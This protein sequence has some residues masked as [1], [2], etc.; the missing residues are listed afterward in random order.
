MPV[1]I[2]PDDLPAVPGGTVNPASALIIDDGAGVWKATPQ[3][4]ADGTTIPASLAARPTS[5]T[6]AASG[7]ADLLGFIQ[8][9]TGAVARTGQS[10]L[11]DVIN[12][13]D[14][15]PDNLRAAIL[16]L[17]S[18]TN[19]TTYVQ[20]A[21]DAVLAAGGGVVQHPVGLFNV[22]GLI[23][24]K[25]VCLAGAGFP[26]T[27]GGGTSAINKTIYK[28]VN[29]G[30]IVEAP[31][32]VA[33]LCGVVGIDFK[34]LGAGTAAKGVRIGATNYWCFI[35]N[36]LFDNFS[37]QAFVA[38]GLAAVIE[39]ILVTN[40]NL[41]IPAAKTGAGEIG[42]TD[43]YANRI[44][45][46]NGRGTVSHATNLYCVG[47]AVTGDNNFISQCVGEFS[48]VGVYVSGNRNRF[49]DVRADLNWGHGWQITGAGNQFSACFSL[50][51]GQATTNTYDNVNISGGN[52]QFDT[53][54][55]DF[56]TATLPRYSLNDSYNS[57]AVKNLY[58]SACRWGAAYGTATFNM[59]NFAGG[60]VQI[61]Q[62]PVKSWGANDA[63]PSVLGY[64]YWITANTVDTTITNFTNPA[65]GQVLWLYINDAKTIVTSG[66]TIFTAERRTKRL[67]TG[68]WYC[69]IF[70]NG[71]WYEMAGEQSFRATA[72]YDPP[73]LATAACGAIQTVAVTGAALGDRVTA[74]FSLDL[75]GAIIFA[76]VSAADTVSYFFQNVNGANPLDLASGTVTVAVKAC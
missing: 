61:P 11:R 72:T 58:G 38:A 7:G 73:S 4:I 63:T 6:L 60:A 70:R 31:D 41:T 19:V 46:S 42:G 29:A 21:V 15:I 56:L 59:N 22:S 2:R 39:D 17:T 50:S 45:A 36:A 51:N 49:T 40:C 65:P 64:G 8:S 33:S 20:A 25:G 69:F 44:E 10:K 9:G 26:G 23:L 27:Y 52:N 67:V 18:T 71:F 34:G 48:D 62:G 16:A 14:F 74:T 47:L 5:A 28:A 54:Q 43:N 57:D 37:G 75:A 13:M 3:Q 55:S 1:P 12:V 68:Q 76:W 30:W 32:S 35:K 24:K 66:G 53:F